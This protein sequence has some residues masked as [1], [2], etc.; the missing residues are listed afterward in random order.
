M[1]T[2]PQRQQVTTNPG[3]TTPGKSVFRTTPRSPVEIAQLGGTIRAQDRDTMTPA[4]KEKYR[5]AAVS[6]IGNKFKLQ[7][8]G[9]DDAA[10]LDKMYDV[11]GRIDEFMAKVKKYQFHRQFMK[12]VT[13]DPADNT[14]TLPTTH[15]VFMDYSSLTANQVRESNKWYNMYGPKY[16]VENLSWSKELMYNSSEP[17]LQEKVQEFLRNVPDIEQGGPLSF[18][19]SVHLITTTTEEATRA[20]TRKI[21]NMKI[22][23]LQGEDVDKAISGIRAAVLHLRMVNREPADLQMMLTEAF[24]TTSVAEFNETFKHLSHERRLGKSQYTADEI[25]AIAEANYHELVHTGKWTGAKTAKKS[26][27]IT[28]WNCNKEGHVRNDCPEPK[29]DG[30]D[31]GGRGR[32]RGGRGR[33][34]GGRNGRGWWRGGGA[35]RGDGGDRNNKKRDPKI[36]D[37][38]MTPPAVQGRNQ[39]YFNGVLHYWCHTCKW[40]TVHI[41]AQHPKNGATQASTVTAPTA[42]VAVAIVQPTMVD[43]AP[44]TTAHHVTFPKTDSQQA[45]FAAAFQASKLHELAEN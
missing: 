20:M 31:G 11:Q 34:R 37:A 35:G 27:F 40:N 21:E 22:R 10:Q 5:V 44:T 16:M 24:Q 25:I 13:P 18:L 41:S 19:L 23:D 15:D 7:P 38:M 2:T 1:S 45:Q 12:I 33:G 3:T 28:C 17:R 14:L 39:Q 30:Q 42:T 6:S 9:A 8:I 43:E 36:L 26:G 4:E 29:K 32:G